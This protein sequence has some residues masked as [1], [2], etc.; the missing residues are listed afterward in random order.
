MPQRDT[1]VPQHASYTV[2]KGQMRRATSHLPKLFPSSRASLVLRNSVAS[3]KAPAAEGKTP[4]SQ[5]HRSD[6]LA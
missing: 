5:V 1:L 3:P 4:A 2:N 6:D